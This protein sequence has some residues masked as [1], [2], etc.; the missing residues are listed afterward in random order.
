VNK[1]RRDELEEM[2]IHVTFTETLNNKIE[3]ISDTLL[4]LYH[5]IR[6]HVQEEKLMF[7]MDVEWMF[8]YE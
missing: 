1:T 6:G 3:D 7:H 4:P 8:T 2:G 5:S